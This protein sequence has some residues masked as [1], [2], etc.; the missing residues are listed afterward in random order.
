MILL[1]TSSTNASI[2][3][4]V[5]CSNPLLLFSV[6]IKL[7]VESGMVVCTMVA[8]EYGRVVSVHVESDVVVYTLVILEYEIEANS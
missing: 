2:V 6:A 5:V 7:D 1:L 8:V 4:G 3:S